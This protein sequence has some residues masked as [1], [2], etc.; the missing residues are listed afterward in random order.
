VGELSALKNEIA[1]LKSEFETMRYASPVQNEEIIPEDDSNSGGFFGDGE[2]DETISLS[3]DELDNIMNNAD[4]TEESEPSDYSEEAEIDDA[5]AE[6]ETTGTVEESTDAL[7]SEDT[8]VEESSEPVMA[9]DSDDSFVQAFEESENN[10]TSDSES[11]EEPVFDQDIAPTVEE[12]TDLPDEMAATVPQEIV[13]EEIQPEEI[14]SEDTDLL[15]DIENSAEVPDDDYTGDNSLSMDFSDENL[16]EPSLDDIETS[17]VEDNEPS[18]E[19]PEEISVPKVDDIIVE[20]GSEDLMQEESAEENSFETETVEEAVEEVTEAVTD[21]TTEESTPSAESE[22]VEEGQTILDT[23]F[24]DNIVADEITEEGVSVAGEQYPW[25]DDTDFSEEGIE[26]K[27]TETTEEAPVME[28]TP[29]GEAPVMEESA[30]V[31]EEAPVSQPSA[32]PAPVS[33]DL[34]SEIKSVLSYMDQLLEN[35]P[36]EK[37]AEFAQSEQ[38]ETYKKLFK[39]LGLA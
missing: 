12:E 35:L 16:E 11:F 33:S 27:D 8:V 22:E 28:E 14:L 38:Y 9:E 1:G 36:E 13:E 30:P 6:I 34:K 39:E 3:T 4:F 26:E 7:L 25:A 24:G 20:S 19:L 31:V 32:S 15:G 29:A 37:I 23:G 5:S 17:M 21:E 10:E 18:E 2:E